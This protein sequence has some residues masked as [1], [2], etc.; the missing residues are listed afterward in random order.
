MT[1]GGVGVSGATGC[2]G[3]AGVTVAAGTWG[4]TIGGTVGFGGVA[5]TVVGAAGLG[6]SA[7]AG[8][9]S[10]TFGACGGIAGTCG[11]GVAGITGS[12]DGAAGVGVTTGLGVIGLLTTSGARGAGGCVAAFTSA[13]VTETCRTSGAF[14][15]LNS[16]SCCR[17]P[18]TS[19]IVFRS[20]SSCSLTVR[21]N[22]VRR[23]ATM[24]AAIAR[25]K[26]L[27]SALP[28]RHRRAMTTKM[29]SA[30]LSSILCAPDSRTGQGA[31]LAI[32][33]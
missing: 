12:E 32:C 27:A 23:M 17:S 14:S 33:F 16:L 10:G 18:L 24:E 31:C 20:F 28:K 22:V 2:G 8:F 7:I 3:A 25:K 30:I 21:A 5:G 9:G 1:R 4:G 11:C 19:S 15:A 6:G 29:S 26:Q 13:S